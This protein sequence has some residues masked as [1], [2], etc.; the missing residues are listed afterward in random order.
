[1]KEKICLCSIRDTAKFDDEYRYSNLLGPG[2]IHW[3]KER[4]GSFKT[5]VLRDDEVKGKVKCRCGKYMKTHLHE[6][7]RHDEEGNAYGKSWYYMIAV[8][9]CNDPEPALMECK[10]EIDDLINDTIKNLEEIR[11]SMKR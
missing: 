10:E 11:S 7:S 6:H 3:L 4:D 1:M 8:C 9:P 2:S 5:G